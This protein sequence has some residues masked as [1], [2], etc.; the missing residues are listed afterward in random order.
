M[1]SPVLNLGKKRAS[2][3]TITEQRSQ[4]FTAVLAADR[5]GYKAHLK[6]QQLKESLQSVSPQ[7]YSETNIQPHLFSH[8]L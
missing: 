8:C 1:I 4:V 7:M 6:A 2:A 3:V 5:D